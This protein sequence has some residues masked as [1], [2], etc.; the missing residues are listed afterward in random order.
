MGYQY[1]YTLQFTVIVICN[2]ILNAV[3]MNIAVKVSKANELREG[4][5][6]RARSFKELRKL[7]LII[8][9]FAVFF[10]CWVPYFILLAI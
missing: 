3:V 8:V 5:I 1:C 6:V 9:I 2:T 10:V 7:K 4:R